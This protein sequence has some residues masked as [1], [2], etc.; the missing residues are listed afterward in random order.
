MF[1]GHVLLVIATER[2][3]FERFSKKELQKRNT[4]EFRFQKI[5]MKNDNKLCVTWKDCNISFQNQDI[6]EEGCKFNQIYLI[7]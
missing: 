2:K 3:L 1:E 6:Q 5:N 4:K 7:M